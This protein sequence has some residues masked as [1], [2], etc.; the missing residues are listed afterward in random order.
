V[1]LD[2]WEF[3]EVA[4]QIIDPSVLMAQETGVITDDPPAQDMNKYLAGNIYLME[5]LGTKTWL[6][7]FLE[8]IESLM[9]KAPEAYA[10]VKINRRKWVRQ[11]TKFVQELGAEAWLV[12]TI[13]NLIG[14]TPAFDRQKVQ[15]QV[16]R[17]RE[18]DR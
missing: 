6:S 18:A 13:S 2:N 8:Q 11:Q 5:H 1:K 12:Q 15:A 16:G 4:T 3:K 10:G 7:L 17:L 14:R 9:A